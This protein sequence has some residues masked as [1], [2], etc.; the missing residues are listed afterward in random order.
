MHVL[1]E[2]YLGRNSKIYESIINALARAFLCN[3]HPGFKAE[4]ARV[5]ACMYVLA[6]YSRHP[7]TEPLAVFG[8]NLM[9]VP[10]I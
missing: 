10:G 8:F 5:Y 9:P 7:N 4:L 6:E 2:Y 3:W 1:A